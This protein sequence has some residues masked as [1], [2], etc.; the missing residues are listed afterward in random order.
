M[1]RFTDGP[2]SWRDKINYVDSNNRVLGFSVERSCCE[3]FG[4]AVTKSIPRKDEDLKDYTGFSDADLEPYEFVDEP[5]INVEGLSHENGGTIALRITAKG[6]QDLFVVIW[7]HHNGYYSHGFNTW[8]E[9][10]GYL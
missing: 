10:D 3:H 4:H 1:K 9:P 5:H 6:Q 7:N 2:A 8:L